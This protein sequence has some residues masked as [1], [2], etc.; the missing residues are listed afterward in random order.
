MKPGTRKEE[1][2]TLISV[3]LCFARWSP[4]ASSTRTR[5]LLK[6]PL[7]RPDSLN[8]GLGSDTLFLTG[9][10][11]DTM[12]DKLERARFKTTMGSPELGTHP[13][14]GLDT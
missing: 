11:G 3:D 8:L 4:L 2:I 7:L 1:E 10:P 14:S 13:L 12:E 5:D 6:I 9:P